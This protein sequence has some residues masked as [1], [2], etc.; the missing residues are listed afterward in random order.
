VTKEK[1]VP[2]DKIRKPLFELD[3]EKVDF[4]VLPA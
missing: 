4:M 3:E 2:A 1:K